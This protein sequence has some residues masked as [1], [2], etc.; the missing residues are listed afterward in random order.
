[1][2]NMLHSNP[3]SRVLNPT[4][5]PFHAHL[6]LGAFLRSSASVSLL[7]RCRPTSLLTCDVSTSFHASTHFL[8]T[9]AEVTTGPGEAY[10]PRILTETEA[11]VRQK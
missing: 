11:K 4:P 1:M 6:P 8:E 3:P 7:E 2:E 10:Q 9:L 5:L